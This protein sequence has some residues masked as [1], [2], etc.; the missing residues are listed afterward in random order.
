MP[1]HPYD[2]VFLVDGGAG[3]GLDVSEFKKTGLVGANGRTISGVVP[4]GVATVE[5]PLRPLHGYP[6]LRLTAPVVNNVFVA[7]APRFDLP[8]GE[9]WL[10]PSGTVIHRVN[11]NQ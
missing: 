7:R 8:T 11:L 10:S 1:R 5:L 2:A 3:G 4:D 9:T 6:H